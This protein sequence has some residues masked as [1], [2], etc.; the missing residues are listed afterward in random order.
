MDEKPF[1]ALCRKLAKTPGEPTV[2]FDPY[3][4]GDRTGIEPRTASFAGLTL[5]TTRDEMLRPVVDALA[6]AS[7][8]RLPLLRVPRDAPQA[9][10]AAQ[11]RPGPRASRP[12]CTATGRRRSRSPPST[13]PPSAAWPAWSRPPD[14]PCIGGRRPATWGHGRPTAHARGVR[15]RPGRLLRPAGRAVRVLLPALPAGR[16]QRR[17]VVP[18]RRQ[19][20]RRRPASGCAPRPTAA[21]P[22]SRSTSSP[23]TPTTP[24]TPAGPTSETTRRRRRGRR[25]DGRRPTTRPSTTRPSRTSPTGRR[26]DDGDPDAFAGEEWKHGLAPGERPPESPRGGRR[27]GRVGGRA[28]EVRRAGPPPAD[29]RRVAADRPPRRP[30]G[31]RRRHQ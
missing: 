2:T 1:F 9:R 19:R 28:A 30:A 5:A 25:R 7:A 10:R 11:R 14:F 8:A 17:H 3:L 13:R 22:A 15:R 12:S 18:A 21:G 4:A 31:D 29:D 27:P 6:V 20:P 26:A 16:R 23:P 24:A